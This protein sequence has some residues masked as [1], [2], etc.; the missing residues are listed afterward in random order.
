MHAWQLL[1]SAYLGER[2]REE[3]KETLK[4]AVKLLGVNFSVKKDKFLSYDKDIFF[5]FDQEGLKKFHFRRR[6]YAAQNLSKSGH[7]MSHAH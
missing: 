1:L 3:R 5:Q 7:I 6:I 2:E 4:T